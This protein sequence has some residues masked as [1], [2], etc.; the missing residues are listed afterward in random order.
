MRCDLA[1]A[2]TTIWRNQ[3]RIFRTDNESRTMFCICQKIFSANTRCSIWIGRCQHSSQ[4][5]QNKHQQK[6]IIEPC[7]QSRA[8]LAQSIPVRIDTLSFATPSRFDAHI[9]PR[10]CS[11][12]NQAPSARTTRKMFRINFL[13]SRILGSIWRP[14]FI[15]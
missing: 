7:V 4:R 6:V 2:Q 10:C 3:F 13:C 9:S 15:R 1:C 11:N 8:L 5:H 12:I 14:F